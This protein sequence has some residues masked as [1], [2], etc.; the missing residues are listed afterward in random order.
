MKPYSSDLRT[1]IFNYALS[2]AIRETA[3]IF[4]VSPNTVYLLKKLV[5]ETGSLES[6]VNLDERPRLITAAGERY[7]SLL[8][9]KENVL[10]KAFSIITAGD[11]KGYFEHASEY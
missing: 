5:H 6:H 8:L 2:H 4:Q 11:A 9:S 1:R 3:K 10:K 7:L